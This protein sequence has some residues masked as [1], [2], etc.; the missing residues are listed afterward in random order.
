M[1]SDYLSNNKTSTFSDCPSSLDLSA[2]LDGESTEL[3]EQHLTNCR[4]CSEKI[5]CYRS[6]DE[7]LQTMSAPPTGLTEDVKAA[8]R[9]S[10]GILYMPLAH[11]ITPQF[12]KSCAAVLVVVF[13]AV[14]AFQVYQYQ[15]RFE[16][17]K[18]GDEHLN[19]AVADILA[20][21]R[22]MITSG[23]TYYGI[24]SSSSYFGMADGYR[25]DTP[26]SKRS[27]EWLDSHSIRIAGNGD[28][29]PMNTFSSNLVNNNP[30]PRT[31]HHVWVVNDLHGASRMFED[32]LPSNHKD[33][34]SAIEDK[35][36]RY[37]VLLNDKQLRELVREL[38]NQGWNL[39]SPATFDEREMN[40]LANFGREVL[41]AVDILATE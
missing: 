8:C 21:K 16:A 17:N 2:W 4:D 13:S 32:M 38:D 25:W 41:Y 33:I 1:S 39:V 10:N 5:K 18:G 23:N 3:D 28:S 6:V 11:V 22:K 24:D 40:D 15:D 9:A 35:A 7:V 27:S 12:L 29:I 34:V 37:K 31:V 19:R 36:L 26:S 30:L 14:F 20:G